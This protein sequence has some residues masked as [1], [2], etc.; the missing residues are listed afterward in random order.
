[1]QQLHQNSS[2]A[3][4]AGLAKRT[5]NVAHKNDTPV[6]CT[7]AVVLPVSRIA[8]VS[9]CEGQCQRR[10]AHMSSPSLTLTRVCHAYLL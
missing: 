4:I 3:V 9:S 2:S 10:D 8:D 7:L 1:M 5:S 6:T